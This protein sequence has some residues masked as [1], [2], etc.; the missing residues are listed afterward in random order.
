MGRRG[1]SESVR[2]E[3]GAAAVAGAGALLVG[4]ALWWARR[5]RGEPERH[6]PGHPGAPPHWFTSSKLGVGTAVNPVVSGTSLV[7]FTLARGI[8]SEVFYPRLD[9]ATT[10]DLGLIVTDGRDFFSEEQ[11][12]AHHEVESPSRGVPAYRL[13]NTCR[14]GRYR[15]E[16]T[17]VSH[18][19]HDAVLQRIRFTPL[20]GDL[21]DY[22]L[23]A[24]LNPHMNNRGVGYG[25]TAWLGDYKGV[26][27]LLAG[28]RGQGLALACS[29]PWRRG[30]AGFVGASD[31]WQDLARHKRMTWEY[32]KAEDG[33]VAL[34]G[35]IDLSACGGEFVLALGLGHDPDEAGHRARAGLLD[36]FD[37]VLA[38]YAR[39]WDDWQGTLLPLESPG[40]RRDLYRVS[41]AVLRTHDAK[42]VPGAM[43]ASLSIPWGEARGDEEVLGT[44]GYHLVWPRD[45]VESAGGYLAAGARDE[46]ARVLRYLRA[47]QADDGSWPQNMWVD[48]IPFWQGKQLGETAFPILLLDLLR[49]EGALDGPAAA[50]FWPMA[51]KAIAHIARS[52]PSTQQ[53]RWE[54]DSGYTPFT[55]AVVVSALLVAAELA[56]ERGEP[57]V[58][59]YLRETADAWNYAV[60]SWLY[61]TGTDLARRVGVEG[62][63]VRIV[64]AELDEESTPAMGRLKLK[65]DAPGR[66]GI[67]ITE[68]VSPDALA[69]VRFGMRAPDDPRVVNTVKVIDAVLKVETPYGPSWRRYNGDHYGEP[70]DGAP[71]RGPDG[72]GIGRAWPLLTG[73]RAHYEFQAGRRAEAVRLLHAVEGFAGPGGLIPEQVWD[74]AD[75]PDKGLHL[76]R[77]TGSAMPLVWAHA[78][79][80][81]LLRTLRDGRVFDLPPLTARRYLEERARSDLVIWRFD[82][83][84]RAISAGEVLRVEV[85]QPAV[86]LWRTGRDPSPRE[87]ATRDTGLGLHVAD[88]ATK[89]L[90][91]GDALR[92]SFRW[93]EDG[94]KEREEFR[95][96]VV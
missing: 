37:V 34:T 50:G 18:P 1:S 25:N 36:D 75:I 31:G 52:G 21:D 78:E 86:V 68:V 56:D 60:E 53:D 15:I 89:A 73:E 16:K 88:L 5:G 92:F 9:C 28:R 13:V 7:W 12:D 77:P 61:V 43:I 54:N 62:Y 64:P 80:V 87:V 35:E 71:Y 58:A 39:G 24:L 49:R 55:L 45:L 66:A 3:L 74:S 4:G 40:R 65:A 96:E 79:Y 63:Y 93:P 67:P 42:A 46:A 76:G 47:T 19:E 90:K 38:E 2:D 83:R 69:L 11:R 81:K 30:S 14:H 27:M 91:A 32:D 8:L 48:G 41:T 95:V 57:A 82:H 20:Q 17:V 29:T 6:A 84:R 94:R 51:R 33:N 72:G 23:Y 22:L 70:E 10:R 26:P 85:L 59:T 44:G